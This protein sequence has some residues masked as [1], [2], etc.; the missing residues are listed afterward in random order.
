MTLVCVV[1]RSD[2]ENRFKDTVSLFDYG[3]ENFHLSPVYWL[4]REEPAGYVVLPKGVESNVLTV[5]DSDS[6]DTRTRTYSYQG[7]DLYSAQISLPVS[8][9]QEENTPS[10][11]FYQ[12][13]GWDHVLPGM[14]I[15]LL[16]LCIS[17]IIILIS[18]A[19]RKKPKIKKK[20]SA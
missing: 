13:R 18:F 5:K 14:G 7:V 4:N 1:L 17:E 12:I 3:F 2:G 6:G 16:I 20:R 8:F 11:S 15:I 19:S 10:S 9:E